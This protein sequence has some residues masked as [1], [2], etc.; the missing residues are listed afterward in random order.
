MMMAQYSS[1]VGGTWYICRDEIEAQLF[2]RHWPPTKDEAFK[3]FQEFAFGAMGKA[4]IV[5][6]RMGLG[7]C[8]PATTMI[9]KNGSL[10]EFV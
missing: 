8:E 5:R 1:L 10:Y 3:T 7:L 6:E 4:R 9:P 2:M